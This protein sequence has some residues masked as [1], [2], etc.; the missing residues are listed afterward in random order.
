[1]NDSS[2]ANGKSDAHRSNSGTQSVPSSNPGY[3]SIE[4]VNDTMHQPGSPTLTL[5][6]P[7]GDLFAAASGFSGEQN[8]L[9]AANA[10]QD[11]REYAITSAD[12]NESDYSWNP[13]GGGAQ[14]DFVDVLSAA[15]TSSGSS[16]LQ[17]IQTSSQI[18]EE[19][20]AGLDTSSAE[21][22]GSADAPLVQS[23]FGEMKARSTGTATTPFQRAAYDRFLCFCRRHKELFRLGV[24]VSVKGT[25]MKRI[26]V[27]IGNLQ[28]ELTG[29]KLMHYK[30][31]KSAPRNFI[32]YSR[33]DTVK[34]M[35]CQGHMLFRS[36]SST[37]D[38]VVCEI[39]DKEDMEPDLTTFEALPLLSRWK[40]WI[41]DEASCKSL[42]GYRHEKCTNAPDSGN[43]YFSD[44]FDG[45]VYKQLADKLGGE[46]AVK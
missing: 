24:D 34:Y 30:G 28:K 13:P 43:Q 21:S 32:K 35:C 36:V 17:P 26:C 5:L 10:E 38:T 20:D 39:C 45:S 25:V 9:T 29:N 19:G 41:A 40:A 6:Q 15:Y 11:C 33:L 27:V 2:G 23:I 18:Q 37:P 44:Y 16:F 12:H 14:Y 31:W 1:M 22:D 7:H 4:G 42:Y 8:N 46:D 3:P